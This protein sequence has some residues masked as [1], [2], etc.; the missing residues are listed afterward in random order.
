MNLCLQNFFSFVGRIFEGNQFETISNYIGLISVKLPDMALFGG[1][2]EHFAEEEEL[3]CYCLCREVE[4]PATKWGKVYSKWMEVVWKC[5][6]L[7]MFYV[8][9]L[10][11]NSLYPL[12]IIYVMVLHFYAILIEIHSKICNAFEKGIV[13]WAGLDLW[14]HFYINPLQT[15]QNTRF[16]KFHSI[17]KYQM[18][19]SSSSLLV[20]WCLRYKLWHYYID[21]KTFL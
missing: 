8:F 16:T 19:I 7:H 3:L 14:L 1:I 2:L 21:T 18:T 20:I 17:L 6:N 4:M 11:C 10:C 13:L 15:F 12:D 9:V 5:E